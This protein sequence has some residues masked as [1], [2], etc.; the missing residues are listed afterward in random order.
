MDHWDKVVERSW[1][2]EAIRFPSGLDTMSEPGEYR[3]VES[4]QYG[5]PHFE[6][7]WRLNSSWSWQAFSRHTPGRCGT[8]VNVGFKSL[9][10]AQSWLDEAVKNK[11]LRA[12]HAYQP[13]A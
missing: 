12:V 3:I 6:P 5:E 8:Q 7:Q 13:A 11:P 1:R 9:R 10:H 4:E 2:W